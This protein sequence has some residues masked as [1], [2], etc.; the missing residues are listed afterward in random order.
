MQ[1][2]AV[3]RSQLVLRDAAGLVWC[4]SFSA[5][6]AASSIPELQQKVL[7]WPPNLQNVHN[8]T[9]STRIRAGFRLI[10]PR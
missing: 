4:R 9:A 6:A 1:S 7:I 3:Q 5:Q 10:V 8:A 2:A